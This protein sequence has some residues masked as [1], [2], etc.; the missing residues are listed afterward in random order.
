M[1]DGGVLVSPL[2]PQECLS[3]QQALGAVR[4]MQKLLA[5]QEAAQLRGTRGLRQQLS[6]LQSRLQRQATKG[7]G[8]AGR[9]TAAGVTCPRGQLASSLGKGPPA[10]R[11]GLA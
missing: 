4:Q 7:N 1:G 3:P 5:A 8:N 2:P 6:L 9:V 10:P 11:Q